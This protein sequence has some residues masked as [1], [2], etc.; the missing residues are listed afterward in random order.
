[1]AFRSR[2]GD[3]VEHAAIVE[4]LRPERLIKEKI[5][6]ARRPAIVERVFDAGA[7]DIFHA[8]GG[9][10][11]GREGI[12]RAAA[13][14]R[15]RG[16]AAPAAARDAEGPIDQGAVDGVA[17]AA[18]EAREIG[19]VR[20]G[21]ERVGADAHRRIGRRR[22]E[23][24]RRPT[25]TVE[26]IQFRLGAIDPRTPLEIIAHIGAEGD[27]RALAARRVEVVL[28]AKKAA[29]RLQRFAWVQRHGA[30]HARAEI[31]PR[32][33]ENGRARLCVRRRSGARVKRDRE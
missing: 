3:K 18:A 17:E 27:A 14:E 31:K 6:G 29:R 13:V 5:L 22:R 16:G 8:R 28:R 23:S 30:A 20:I 21:R 25:A 10:E 33:A 11:A 24:S 7:G 12:A 15:Q 4:D 32:P 19:S 9:G 26:E 2:L 1:V